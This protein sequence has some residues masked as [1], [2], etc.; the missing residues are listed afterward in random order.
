MPYPGA[1]TPPP[2]AQMYY[3]PFAL[4]QNRMAYRGTP[5]PPPNGMMYPGTPMPPPNGMMYPGTPMPPPN[6]MMYPDAPM[7][8]RNGMMYTGAPMP[9]P[10][11]YFNTQ[12]AFQ[13]P[14]PD[15]QERFPMPETPLP[16]RR[17]RHHRH[18]NLVPK[19]PT[20]GEKK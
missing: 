9:S 11:G 6:G 2:D 14:P 12:P 8:P 1:S 19:G 10:I 17:N 13:P 18:S 4:V 7:P 3:D 16:R 20:K 15:V 5:M